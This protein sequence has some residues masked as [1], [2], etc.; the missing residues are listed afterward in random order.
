MFERVRKSEEGLV[1][2][3]LPRERRRKGKLGGS[4][5]RHAFLCVSPAAAVDGARQSDNSVQLDS[6]R[7]RHKWKRVDSFS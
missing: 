6:G 1:L 4:R 2:S 7:V 5:H 3:I